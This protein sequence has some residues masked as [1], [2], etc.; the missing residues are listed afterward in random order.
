M[1][2]IF[3]NPAWEDYLYWQTTDKSILKKINS[4]IKEIER[5]PY[6]GSGK[7]E[8]LKHNLAGWWSRRI[9]LEHRLIYRVEADAI[10]IL[11]CRYHY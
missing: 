2:I 8:P 6:E 4:L 11:Q 5:T 9:N 3:Q 1:K 7:P 10:F